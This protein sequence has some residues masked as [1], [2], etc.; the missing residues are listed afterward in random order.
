ME[1]MR[2]RIGVI[3]QDF[4]RFYLKASENIA[5]GNIAD[6][7][8]REKIVESAEKSLASSVVD[9]L[10]LKYDQMLG[11]RFADGVELSGGEWQKVALAR[12]YMRDAEILILDEP[13]AA[14]DARAEYEVF[15]RF[16]E[17]TAGKTAVLISHRFSTVRM[18]DRILVL[19]NGRLE[20]LG[21]HE[22]L[23]LNGGLYAELFKLQAA[24]YQ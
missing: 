2:E 5:V 20:E 11:R 19:K 8:D 17:L 15:V 22:E 10:P 16:S 9:K 24:G 13:T 18:A 23:L 4:V 6:L 3:F 1:S 21:T 7:D 12:A 14:L